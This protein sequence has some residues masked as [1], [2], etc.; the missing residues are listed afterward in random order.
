MLMLHFFPMIAI[1]VSMGQTLQEGSSCVSKSF[2][3]AMG[4]FF[5]TNCLYIT[6]SY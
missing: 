5:V 4:Y 2:W 3:D 1:G 6:L